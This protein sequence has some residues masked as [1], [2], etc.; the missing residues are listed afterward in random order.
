MK[1]FIQLVAAV[2]LAAASALAQGTT[3]NQT[4]GPAPTNWVQ[5]FWCG[6]GG[7]A[8]ASGNTQVTFI[9]YAPALSTTTTY[10]IG[11]TPELT[12]IVVLTNVGTI[13]FA[14]TAQLWVGQRVTVAG[15]S[16]S[17]LNGTYRINS[18]SGTTAT[19]TTSGVSNATYNNAALTVSTSQP[20]LSAS[21]WAIQAFPFTDTSV[22]ATYF[23]GTP[24]AG[25]V[26]SQLA[27]S[28][29]TAY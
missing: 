13:N 19:I 21:V 20:I 27:C 25:G 22:N 10:A 8:C 5:L 6:T 1:R 11:S 15:S 16:T 18:V 17:A 7:T 28:N 14:A 3:V 26:P 4:M 2:C 9:C 29:R 23:A 24:T 12:S